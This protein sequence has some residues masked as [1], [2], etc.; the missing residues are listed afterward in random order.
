MTDDLV[1]RLAEIVTKL[2]ETRLLERQKADL[3][4]QV[5]ELEIEITKLHAQHASLARQISAS[6][7][8]KADLDQTILHQK[9]EIARVKERLFGAAA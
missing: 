3:L 5:K 4:R 1:N 8:I 2:N 9:Q 6:Q 7:Q